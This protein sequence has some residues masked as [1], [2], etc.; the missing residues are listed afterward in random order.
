MA[1]IS[2]AVF[3]QSLQV[4]ISSPP[5]VEFPL[6]FSKPFNPLLN[7][8]ILLRPILWFSIFNP[9]SFTTATP[10]VHIRSAHNMDVAPLAVSL[11]IVYVLQERTRLGCMAECPGCAVVDTVE[12]VD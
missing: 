2:R 5:V 10:L 12:A 6:A 7:R 1:G 8:S 4:V 11:S 3:L 9:C